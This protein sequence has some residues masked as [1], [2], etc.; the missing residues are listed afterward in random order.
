MKTV[1]ATVVALVV[2]VSAGSAYFA[3]NVTADARSQDCGDWID[4]TDERVQAARSLLY[5]S[6]RPGAFQGSVQQAAE[7][8]FLLYEEQLNSAPPDGAG[9]LNDDL[10]EAMS[11]GAE[12][13]AGSG[14]AA[15]ETQIV[16]AKAIVYNADARLLAVNNAVC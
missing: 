2:V 15:P 7:E 9:Q 14:G 8:M 12:G 1:V 4:E 13:L 5:P 6:D 11:V 10:V 3:A 16:F